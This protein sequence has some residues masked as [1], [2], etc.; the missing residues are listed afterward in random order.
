MYISSKGRYAV[1]VLID[2][3]LSKSTFTSLSEIAERQNISPKYLE[4]VMNILIKNKFIESQM[5]ANGG[6]RLTKTPKEYSV[7]DILK[8]TGDT[9]S[10]A[11]CQFSNEKC[12][13]RNSCTSVGYWNTLQ[14]LINDN[15][16]KITLQDILDSNY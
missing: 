8:L 2:L 7:Y 13:M 6:Y 16:N 14:K 4:K 1:R 3:A 12:S 10:L 5:G 9:P 11:P 15:L